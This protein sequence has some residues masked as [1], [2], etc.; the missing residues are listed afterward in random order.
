MY[1][2]I[3]ALEVAIDLLNQSKELQTAEEKKQQKELANMMEDSKGKAFI[4]SMT[5]QCFRSKN[6]ARVADQLSFLIKKYGIPKYLSF[7]KKLKL[8]LFQLFG[9]AFPDT[10]V[11]LV[12]KQ[13]RFE[14][15][16]VV[17]PSEKNELLQHL[18]QRRVERVKININHLGE[19]VLGEEE[20]EKRVRTYLEDLADPEIECISV[21]V[22][23]IGSQLNLLAW[24]ETLSVLKRRL[25]LLYRKAAEFGG[26]FVYLDMEEY[27]DLC[28][29]L[30]LFQQVLSEP[31]FHKYSAG[32]VLQSYIPDS[33]IVQKKLT[34][35]ALD[36]V[37]NGGA[38]IKIRI[39]KGA[40]LAME[41]VDAAIQ[42][43]P[44]APYLTKME[45]DANFKRMIRYGFIREHAL[46]VSI[47]IGSHN[48]F[49]IAYAM[50]MRLKMGVENYVSFEMLEG[51]ADAIRKSIQKTVGSMLL[52]CPVANRNEF[53]NAI[54][55]LTRR[56]DE[57]TS[58][59]N[60]LRYLFN[61]NPDSENWKIQAD[62]FV[63]SA[64]KSHEEMVVVRRIQNRNEEPTQPDLL[65]FSNEPS[66][67]WS[68]IQNRKWAQSILQRKK[69]IF[70]IPVVVDGEEIITENH[71]GNGIDPS[72]PK[73]WAYR[74]SKANSIHLER[75]LESA[76]RAKPIKPEL[77]RNVAKEFR[78]HRAD[79]I[80]AMIVDTGKTMF[81][82]DHEVSEAIDFIEYY[83]L[84]LNEFNHL[85]CKP[86]GTIVVA[87]PWNFPCAIP[88][89]GIAAALVTGNRVIFKPAPEAIHVGFELA[90][91]FWD[92]G[93][94]KD[95]LQFFPCEDDPAGSLL[96]K[97]PRVAG[98]ILTG[99]TETAEKM[100]QMRPDL[101]LLAET[102]GK[103]SLIISDMADRDLAI[104]DLIQSAFSHSGQKCSACSLAI[105]LPEVY[106]DPH[107]RNQLRDAVQSLQ[108]GSAW[109][110]ATK[111]NPLI[112]EPNEVLMRALT[113][114]EPGEQWLLQPK[115]DPENPYLWSPGIKIGVKK[116]S[117]TYKNE[118][119]GPVL[120]IMR[121]ENLKHAIELANGTSYGLTSGLHSLDEREHEFWIKHIVAGN[122]YINRSITG[123]LVR[124][125]PF[126]GCKQ[127]SF[128]PGAKAGGPNYLMQ[129]MD[130]V[131]EEK[132]TNYQD[133]W[134]DFYNVDH[135]PSQ[136][137]GESN[138]LRYV[139]QEPTLLYVQPQ[140]KESDIQIVSEAAKMCKAQLIVSKHKKKNMKRVRFLS[141]PPLDILKSLAEE[142][143]HYF[144]APAHT[145]G[146]VELFHHLREVSIS[147]SYHRYGWIN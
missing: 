146:R 65:E 7:S 96:I 42:G 11:P 71:F 106:E 16:S 122:L 121:A 84:N 140:D 59:E 142:N 45:V 48:L 9:K 110:F 126:G 57:N 29:T 54:A 15:K 113:T 75:A 129:L 125:Q 22:S 60:F 8:K 64:E 111:I 131:P 72:C 2:A 119:F 19:A 39:V 90:K 118:L 95:T 3:K 137:L 133:W 27:K 49:E 114:L 98:V 145:D 147:Y 76:K 1:D 123:A 89:G 44:Q 47:G 136:I 79:L 18:K 112:R 83:R 88:T 70:P 92:G 105:C 66:T 81:E 37:K 99:S 109:D 12:K 14:T 141:K 13:L 102:G 4:T 40:N 17:L 138:I 143:I 33:Y 35:W 24:D 144:V 62:L 46:A 139:P 93:V 10:F 63:K 116:D 52:Y 5:D 69:P 134:N 20:A 127:S 117:F 32:I 97:D 41:R 26:K 25:K 86:K 51:M 34:E 120:G 77:L 124:R 82:A 132:K 104:R 107:F 23:T 28:L 21:K 100:L 73:V 68:L 103:N 31:E 130:P 87:P 91:L 56:L 55:Y 115:Q 67:D 78:S 58:P 36:R 43:W 50:V 61:L 108:V 38:P 80:R 85:N 135:D 94:P 128:G 30:D 101:H 6:N 53:V 74:Y